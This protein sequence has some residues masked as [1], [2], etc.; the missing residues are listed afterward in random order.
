VTTLRWIALPS[1]SGS[2]LAFVFLRQEG[3]DTLADFDEAI[4][5]I[6]NVVQAQRLFGGAL[7][8][9][10]ILVFHPWMWLW[11]YSMKCLR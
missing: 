3:E 5:A 7:R 4:A 11:L 8:C 6:P 2:T 9:R 1:A 10:F